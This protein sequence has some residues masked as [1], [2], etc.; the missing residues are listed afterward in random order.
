VIAITHSP[1]VFPRLTTRVALT[2]AGHTHGG[3][4]LVPFVGAPWVPSHL[5]QR[6]LRG[7]YRRGRQALYVSSG[8]G[9]SIVPLRFRVPPEVNLLRVRP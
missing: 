7:V 1:D 5:G 4:L 2:L 6:Y 3:Q 9:Q 8:V